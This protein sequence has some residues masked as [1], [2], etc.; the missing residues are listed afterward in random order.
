MDAIQII[1]KKRDGEEL[2]SSEI[3]FLIEGSTA[4]RIPDYQMSAFLMA[5]QLRGMT[6][7]ETVSLT[8]CMLNSGRTLNFH[9]H[10]ASVIDKHST[11]GVGDK[12]SLILAPIVG[13]CGVCLPMISGRG[14]GHT[15][16]TLDKLES[17][18]GFRTNLNIPDIY[19]QVGDLGVAMIGATKEIAPADRQLYALRDVT[20]SVDFIPFITASIL[21]KKLA[22]GLDGLVLDVKS[23]RGA[24]MT[25][26]KQARKLAETL[27]NVGENFGMQTVAWLTNMNVPLGHAV[28]NWLEVEESIECLRG[29]GPK[30]VLD[31]SIKLSGEMIALA[32]LADSPQEGEKMARIAVS[33]GKGLDFLAK[34]VDAQG[35]DSEIIRDPTLRLRTLEP[36]TITVP[37]DINAYVADIDALAI[38]EAANDMG[39]GRLVME[40]EIDPEA[41]IILHLRTG[42]KA[43]PGHPLA[44]AYTRKTDQFD[45]FAR[46]ILNAYT[47]SQKPV[48]TPNIFIDRLTADGWA[49]NLNNS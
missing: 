3:Q 30:D 15:G 5:S 25:E 18:P 7:D 33:S 11:G 19:R 37:L 42:D 21:S 24:F 13:A 2:S 6:L 41:G 38:A 32:N 45:D 44:S 36:Q 39:A 46:K 43:T 16:G 49:S 1:K 48:D 29:E 22:E 8:R 4:G 27:V 26:I 23:G 34:I 28:G 40:D 14:L 9:S 31:L 35:G 10:S 47:L 20:A 12:I 17:I